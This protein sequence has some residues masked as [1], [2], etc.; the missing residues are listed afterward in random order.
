MSVVFFWLLMYLSRNIDSELSKRVRNINL[1]HQ[2][3]SMCLWYLVSQTL[4]GR[5]WC[6]SVIGGV[7][8]C[9][10][11]DVEP[12][13]PCHGRGH[14]PSTSAISAKV[15]VQHSHSQWSDGP[16]RGDEVVMARVTPIHQDGNFFFF[17]IQAISI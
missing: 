17:L 4:A 1:V 5:G 2:Y 8:G 10:D 13:Y 12:H 7:S 3:K 11:G 9:W 16:S 15:E 14:S 6:L